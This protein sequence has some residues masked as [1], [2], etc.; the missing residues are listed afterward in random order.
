MT[1]RHPSPRSLEVLMWVGVLGAGLSWALM[2]LFGYGLSVG[3]CNQFLGGSDPFARSPSVPFELWTLIDTA[4]GAALA[5]LGIAAAIATF[6]VSRR[7]APE[8]TRRELAGEGS[9]PPQGRIQFMSIIGMVVS[10]LFLCIIL[11]SGLGSYVLAGCT[12]S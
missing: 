8:L 7:G 9:Q 5:I 10:P 12:Q 2:F 3:A 4:I 6:R 1:L 11:V